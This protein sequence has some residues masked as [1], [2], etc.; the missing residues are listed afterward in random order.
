MYS[1]FLSPRH[2]SQWVGTHQ[3]LNRI[4]YHMA[5]EKIDNG[6]FPE[7]K[8]IQSFE[9]L[10]GPDGIKLKSPSQ[11]EP[12]HYYDPL[13]DEDTQLI[14]L[15]DQHYVSLVKALK[16]HNMERA[17]FEAS[18]LSHGITDGLTPAHQ[19]PYE[20]E[21]QNITGKHKDT[22]TTRGKKFFAG[23]ETRPQR[24]K[25]NWKLWGMKGLML[26]HQNFEIGVA[27]IAIPM[28]LKKFKLTVKEIEDAVS[29]GPTELFK[30]SARNIAS[31]HMYDRFYRSGWNTTLG[32][33]VREL[34]IP[35]I[36]KTVALSWL[37][38]ANEATDK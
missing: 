34:L 4:S 27:A 8:T 1:G 13:D 7:I 3:K 17:G 23:G 5:I 18:W 12:W 25:N 38:A 22:R 15:L 36:S 28:R 2:S 19:Y 35:A 37:M 6:V 21:L 16:E 10:N 33:D 9:G 14:D 11:N 31:Y 30:K 20:K 26:T 29:I 24:I 32:K